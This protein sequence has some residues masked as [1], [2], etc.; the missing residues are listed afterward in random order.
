MSATEPRREK[1]I[2]NELME[3]MRQE[4]YNVVDKY[5]DILRQRTLVSL[6]YTQE[7]TKEEERK[8]HLK[9]R[10]Q[11]KQILVKALEVYKVGDS[12]TIYEISEAT[13][14]RPFDVHAFLASYDNELGVKHDPETKGKWARVR[15]FSP[16]K[17]M[18]ED[19]QAEEKLRTT[20]LQYP[21]GTEF[22]LDNL[23][24]A[25][26]YSPR[27]IALYLRPLYFSHSQPTQIM[28]KFGIEE[29][30]GMSG[31]NMVYKKVGNYKITAPN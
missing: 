13:G 19:P 25:T 2:I 22:T 23:A 17:R 12:F 21:V 31:R 15:E 14:L 29:K 1:S 26:G 18:K 27:S 28:E 30:F 16:R 3:Q 11:R 20:I 7:M 6:Q 5:V 8:Q 10:P 4:L 24:D 9:D